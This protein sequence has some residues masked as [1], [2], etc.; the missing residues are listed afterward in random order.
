[1]EKRGAAAGVER[2]FAPSR[3]TLLW[4]LA[5]LALTGVF[6]WIIGWDLIPWLRGPAPYPPEW[7]WPWVPLPL[8]KIDTYVHLGAFILYP[9]V[10]LAVLHPTFIH[11]KS[12]R[13]RRVV[14]V[15]LAVL[16]FFAL[17][18]AMAAARKD[19]LLE[20]II[21][22]TYA[23]PGNGYF[24]S[25]VRAD[26][27]WDTLTHYAAA[28]PNFPHD[29]PRTHP[30][31]IFMYYAG[32]NWLFERLP[33]FSAWFA[34]IARSWAT[35]DRD[36]VQLQDPYVTS[37]FFSGLV[38][39]L[40]MWPAPI[41]F[42]ALLRRLEGK[43][44]DA[45][46]SRYGR[47]ALW[48]AMLLPL[49]PSLSSFYSHWDVNYL[50]ISFTAW[51]LAV[52][53]QDRLH[54]E[55]AGRVW[56]WLDWLLAGLLLSLLTWLSFGNAVITAMIGAHLLWRE[57]VSG[58]WRQPSAPGATWRDTRINWPELGRFTAGALLMAAGLVTPWLL[59]YVALHINYFEILRV[60]MQQHYIIVNNGRDFR[61]WRWMNLVDFAL[62]TSPGVVLLG[63]VGSVWLLLHWRRGSLES[64][65]AGLAL[66]FWGVLLVLNFSGTARAEIG[67]LWIFL[68]PFPLLF[69]LAY[70]RTYG[71]RAVVMAMLALSAWLMGFALR[72]V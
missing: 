33:G 10:V 1:M 42:Y 17:Q 41:A 60:G 32:W 4:T 65:L 40:L 21:F 58:K 52:R 43:S 24:M 14:G 61:I 37:A 67:R 48:G 15:A 12:E 46:G 64:N 26:S 23:P 44:E 62:W 34:P 8:N 11:W 72:A 57:V 69:A 7:D 29:R 35:P 38:Q 20:L 47:Y 18:M 55:A 19:N 68:M 5:G 51:F 36:W 27:I 28:M 56:R 3:S 6:A 16:G 45:A 49:L 71:L 54:G 30:P 25:A 2:R 22:R 31:M 70:V 63:L 53:A 9:L 13:Q 66:I 39:W 59:A 50:L